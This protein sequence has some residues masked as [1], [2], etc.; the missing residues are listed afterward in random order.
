MKLME[1]VKLKKGEKYCLAY[2]PSRSIQDLQELDGVSL[3]DLKERTNAVV[4]CLDSDS[5]ALLVRDD[6]DIDLETTSDDAKESG[7]ENTQSKIPI[8]I[9]VSVFSSTQIMR[10]CDIF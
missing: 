1:T 6:I 5:W 10:I 3:K 9:P 4:G 2:H 7:L 8:L